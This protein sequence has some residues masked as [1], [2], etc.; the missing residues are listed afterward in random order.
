MKVSAITP[1]YV[2]RMPDKL[3]EGR[4][5]ISESR[6]LAMHKCCCGCGEEVVTPLN[7]KAGWKVIKHGEM[8]SLHPSIGNWNF[9]CDSHY[10]IKNNVVDW[11]YKMTAKEISRVQE[12]DLKDTQAQVAMQ[13]ALKKAETN[14]NTA[15]P[16]SAPTKPAVEKRLSWFK[17]IANWLF[18]K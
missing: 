12:R 4:L 8:V 13:N 5:Y 2:E 7:T 3:E 11:S 16:T 10:W 1:V 17:T 15:T 18:G 6:N 14:A 9:A